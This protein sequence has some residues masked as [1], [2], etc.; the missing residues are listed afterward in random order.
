MIRLL[1]EDVTVNRGDAITAHV[2][3][4]GGSTQT[5]TLPIPL[6]A[7]ELKKTSSENQDVHWN[8]PRGCGIV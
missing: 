2:R 8:G 1:I 6:R 5:L 7:W 4:R 3:F